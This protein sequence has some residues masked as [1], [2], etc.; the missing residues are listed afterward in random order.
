[1]Y[2]VIVLYLVKIL[3]AETEV[4]YSHSLHLDKLTIIDLNCNIISNSQK[5]HLQV[6]DQT[7][8]IWTMDLYHPAFIWVS[9]IKIQCDCEISFCSNHCLTNV[10]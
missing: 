8:W 6:V 5:L 1:M 10:S 3:K 7:M 4:F 2:L 9:S